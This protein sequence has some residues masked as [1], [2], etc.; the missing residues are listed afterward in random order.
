METRSQLSGTQDGRHLAWRAAALIVL[1]LG[2]AC[3][4]GAD[5]DAADTAQAAADRALREQISAVMTAAMADHHLRALI[6]RV[7]VDG[8]D[9][10]TSAL[11]ES[12]AGVPATTEMH[13][14]NGA[15][16]FTYM[17][18]LL[19]ILAGRGSLDLDAPISTWLPEL[20]HA[21]EITV[22][23]LANMTSGYADYVYEPQ[24]LVGT[25]ADPFRQWRNEELLSIGVSRPLMF[26]PGTNWGYSHTNYLILGQVVEH[27][28]RRPLAMVMDDEVL[29]PMGLRNTASS[30]TAA[31]PPPVLHSYSSERR[32]FLQIPAGEPFVEDST[33]W[34]P[35]WTTV[36]GAVQTTDIT[37]LATTAEKVGSGALVT[38]ALYAQQVGNRLVGLGER[39]AACPVCSPITADR[40]YGLGVLLLGKWI[41]QTKDF[42][43]EGGAMAYL[44]ERKVAIAVVT[45]L[46]PEAYDK[47][48]AASNPSMPVMRRLGA[49]LAPDQP[50]G[51]R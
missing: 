17:G 1:A 35:S 13:F 28:T 3:G 10:A 49:L 9:I 23:M 30:T 8:R 14:R 12:M 50:M 27:L 44:P 15:V 32:T 45:T 22:R 5:T 20:P 51:P 2:S 41:A 16:S 19:A 25:D 36:S 33:F 46:R 47:G 18:T 21:S 43:G 7:T 38:P 40:G 31:I 37:D 48:G 34:N 6:V 24:V 39:T 11:G 4:G 42:A 26:T 29:R